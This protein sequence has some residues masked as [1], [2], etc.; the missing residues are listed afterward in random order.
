MILKRQSPGKTKMK[1]AA[2]DPRSLI[3]CPML[4]ILMASTSEAANQSD[5]KPTRMANSVFVPGTRK[6]GVPSGSE[7]VWIAADVTFSVG[8]F[9][10]TEQGKPS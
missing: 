4:G 2:K 6:S 3:T 10:T 9:T 5:T 1:T 8:F 7:Q